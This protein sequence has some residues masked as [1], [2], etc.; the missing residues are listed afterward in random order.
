MAQGLKALVSR[1]GVA[2]ERALLIPTWFSIRWPKL[3]LV[4]AGLLTLASVS[5][6]GEGRERLIATA[7]QLEKRFSERR[8]LVRNVY[9]EQDIDF[10]IRH[11]LLYLPP[12]QLRLVRVGNMS[13]L[14]ALHLRPAY[15]P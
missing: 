6:E 12:E 14:F 8:D 13:A 7:R 5:I 9:F 1:I 4:I 11:A 10:F 15:P 2:L 3:V